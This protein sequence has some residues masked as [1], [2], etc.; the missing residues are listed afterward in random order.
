MEP[1]EKT[2]KVQE[3]D[4]AIS[5]G[6]RKEKKKKDNTPWCAAACRNSKSKGYRMFKF[7][8]EFER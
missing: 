8:K 3:S 5:K 6:Q 1:R 7:P 2:D 4:A